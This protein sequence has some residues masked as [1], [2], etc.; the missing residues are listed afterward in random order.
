VVSSGKICQLR[1][2]EKMK[3]K[4]MTLMG[5]MKG[6]HQFFAGAKAGG[7]NMY[8]DDMVETPTKIQGKGR[9]PSLQ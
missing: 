9:V 8:S 4:G 1:V 5:R 6:V 3:E 7:S 2:R